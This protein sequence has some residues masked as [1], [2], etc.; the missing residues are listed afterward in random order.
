ISA[1]ARISVS[2]SGTDL[3]AYYQYGFDST[4]FVRLDPAFSDYLT[5]IYGDP[6]GPKTASAEKFTPLLALIDGGIEPLSARY[7]RRHHVG[8]DVA[9][10]FGPVAVRVDAAYETKRVF[11]QQDLASFASPVVLGV[12]SLEYQTGSLDDV[13]LLE[14][15][16]S[17]LLEKPPLPLLAYKRD[18]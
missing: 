1:G 3:D 18:T 14:V 11:Y 10:A 7:L 12:L 13:L 15:L 9:T 2:L 4:P 5:R 6:A 8:F 17:H 16:G